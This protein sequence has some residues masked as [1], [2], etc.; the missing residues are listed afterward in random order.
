MSG[1]MP[2]MGGDLS[3]TGGDGMLS[4][5]GDGDFGEYGMYG[6]MLGASVKEK[7]IRYS[8][9]VS[10]RYVFNLYEQRKKV[11][12]ALHLPLSDPRVRQ[13]AEEFIDLHVERKQAIPSA[14]PWAGEWES[15]STDDLAEILNESLGFDLEVVVAAVTRSVITMPLPRRAQGI[16]GKEEASHRRISDFELS[17]EEK[18]LIRKRDEK[19]AKELAERKAKLPPSR[20]EKKGFYG[21]KGN[22]NEMM[23]TMFGGGTGQDDFYDEFGEDIQDEMS[24]SSASGNSGM[25]KDQLAKLRKKLFEPSAADR[26]LLVRFMDFTVERGQQYIYR[27]RLELNNPN[28]NMPVDQLEQPE[29]A[30]Q[31]TIMSD[32]SVPTAPVFVPNEYRYYVKK[33]S[34]SSDEKAELSMYYEIPDKGTPVM[35][36]F[37]VPLGIRI[38]AEK[39]IDVVDLSKSVLDR[40]NVDLRSRDIL[41][42]VYEA[43]KFS[44]SDHPDLKSWLDKLPRGQKPIGDQI[45]VMTSA[46][47]LVNRSAG[48]AIREMEKDQGDIDFL[49][50]EYEKIG[51]RK[52]DAD[53]S[54]GDPFGGDL[55]GGDDDGMG[56]M[57]D[58]GYGMGEGDPLSGGGR[59]GRG[60]SGR[61]GG[62]FN[63]RGGP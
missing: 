34:T 20:A 3:G 16:W 38:G 10:V 45:T 12:E 56:G 50:K 9:A 57:A 53:N 5:G 4:L 24:D 54:T 44:S 47:S 48:D 61:R 58:G 7:R 63:G 11:A 43:P 40:A 17:V 51:W 1:G 41:C 49:I 60:G 31:K 14:D 55:F 23:T 22:A 27:V 26:L 37:S 39:D 46:G 15:V 59:A 8:A 21:F 29:L 25:N 32:W 13:Y 33:A 28:F 19:L 62:G 30:T 2:G 35:A 18:E 42:S 52:K 36:D 6:G